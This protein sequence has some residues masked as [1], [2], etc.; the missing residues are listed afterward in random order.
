MA[1]EQPDNDRIRS[2]GP[3]RARIGIDVKCTGDW[4][5]GKI[6]Q[7]KLRGFPVRICCRSP[8][9]CTKVTRRIRNWRANRNFPSPKFSKLFADTYLLSYLVTTTQMCPVIYI[10]ITDIVPHYNAFFSIISLPRTMI[11]SFLFLLSDF[12]G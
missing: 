7:R 6:L 4:K 12:P 1:L 9:P 10:I 3:A 2:I 8:T 5:G 11:V